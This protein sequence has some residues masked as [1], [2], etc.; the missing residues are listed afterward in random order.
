MKKFLSVLLAASM[1]AACS[2]DATET[3]KK[4]ATEETKTTAPAETTDQAETTTEA[5]PEEEKTTIRLAMIGDV[6]LHTQILYYKDYSPALKPM[7]K[8]LQNYDYL[9]ANQESLAIGNKFPLSGYPRFS[10]PDFIIRDVKEAGA[11]MLNLANNHILDH[12]EAAL[13][14]E[15]ENIEKYDLPY[16]GAY[17][18][19]KDANKPRV[20]D[21]DG[22]KIGVVSYTYGTN[23]FKVPAGKEYLVNYIDENKIKRDI[24][25]IKKLSDVVVVNMHWGTEYVTKEN[26]TQRHLA[27]VINKAG[28]DIIFGGHPHVIQPYDEIVGKDGH[29][30]GVFY[31][32]G[33]FYATITSGVETMVGGA[34]SFR[35]TKQGDEVTV[36]K[37]VFKASAVLQDNGMYKVF[38]LAKVEGKTPASY[39]D[40][41]WV[42]NIMGDK[43]I[44]K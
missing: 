39:T 40:L 10:S 5:Q 23:G 30:T 33:N 8:T 41:K 43:V 17:Q 29:K 20:V 27:K 1:L 2:N 44:V 19:E 36:D 38:P 26:D 6:L 16:V 34:A 22:I 42:Q 31:S 3:E 4:P 35:I 21:V 13:R 37:P 32:I 14:T 24:K 28:G 15:F 12:G 11:D 18:S 25:K 9:I 7:E